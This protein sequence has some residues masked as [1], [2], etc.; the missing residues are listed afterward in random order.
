M[1]YNSL[2]DFLGLIRQTSNG[3]R[4]ESMPG[5]DYVL[6]ALARAGM[7][8]LHVSA[9]EP[10]TDQATTAWLQPA[11]AGSWTGEGTLFLWNAVN[12][13]YEPATPALWKALIEAA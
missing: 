7:F 1:A 13:A 8:D 5:M 11:S 12:A 10:T 9:T 6:A 2:T 3:A 4:V